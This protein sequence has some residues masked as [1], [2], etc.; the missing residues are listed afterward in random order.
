MRSNAFFCG[1]RSQARL[2]LPD[3]VGH[4]HLDAGD[5][6]IGYQDRAFAQARGL[7]P[8]AD[9]VRQARVLLVGEITQHSDRQIAVVH[10]NDDGPREPVTQVAQWIPELPP[11]NI[12]FRLSVHRS[13]NCGPR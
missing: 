10:G 2:R 4:V 6:A 12:G 9:L 7:E 1:E 11:G 3:G 8:E 13:L 5:L